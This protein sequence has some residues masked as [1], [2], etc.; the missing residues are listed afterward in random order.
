MSGLWRDVRSGWQRQW[1]RASR[2]WS[3]PV[4]DG[5]QISAALRQL[6][7]PPQMVLVH[8]SLAA[9][10]TIDGGAETVIR[11][12][13]DW[14]GAGTLAMPAH[15]YCYPSATGEAAV[16]DPASTPSV[17]GAITD[18]YWRMP[19]V[20]RSLHP[21][22]S[23]AAEGAQA[24]IIVRDHE[25]CETPCGA[26][27]PYE[28][29][30]MMGA[31]V[32]M[33]GVGMHAYTLFHTAEDAAMVPYLYHSS[34]VT[35]RYRAADGAVHTMSM[36]RHDMHVPRSFAAKSSWLEQQGQLS[37]L[38]LGRGEL[39]FIRDARSVHA[40]LVAQLRS[41]PGFLLA[42]AAA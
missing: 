38:S 12:L 14:V 19:G 16:F 27:S 31:S 30:V 22:H 34:P 24:A 4:I 23:L 29:L 8:S 28:R 42:P 36:R 33:F 1:R 20:T 18:V 5:N 25:S 2:W 3:A 26:G 15:S 10:G 7:A 41:Q 32:L 37:R 6:S 40:A 21:T 9:C 11:A 39:L 35:L 13:R 17:V